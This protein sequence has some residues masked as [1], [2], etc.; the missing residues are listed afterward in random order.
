MSARE[1]RVDRTSF[2]ERREDPDEERLRSLF[3]SAYPPLKL[4]ASL[5][6]QM[7]EEIARRNAPVARYWGWW[8]LP[9]RGRF[10]AAA[11]ATA[12]L[13]AV[14]GFTLVRR[15]QGRLPGQRS[16]TVVQR[17]RVEPPAPRPGPYPPLIHPGPR[18]VR[19][20]PVP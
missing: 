6:E 9:H 4:T 12:L 13:L 18:V 17:P 8:P 1:P 11:M 16:R 10:A 2:Q 15:G 5:R 19:F 14:L 3:A 20:L 7:A